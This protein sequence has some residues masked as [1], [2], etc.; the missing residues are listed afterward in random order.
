LGQI[1]FN[2]GATIQN[3]VIWNTA[4]NAAGIYILK[5]KTGNGVFYKK[6]NVE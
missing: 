2:P 3:S 1:V 4:N 5:I 6:I